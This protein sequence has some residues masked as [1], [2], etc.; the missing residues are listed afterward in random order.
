MN[1]WDVAGADVYYDVRNEF[2]KDTHGVKHTF[3]F[4]TLLQKKAILIYDVTDK[5]SF[6]SLNKWIDE[7]KRLCPNELTL[8]LVANKIDQE[9]RSVYSSEGEKF[10]QEKN[11]KYFETSAATGDG[12]D[13]LFNTL[14]ED[15]LANNF[16][17]KPE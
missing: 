1:F 11:I 5:S 6:D 7:L 8:I 12:V 13:Q 17:K 2:Y 15:I 10:A 4:A 9:P 16:G 14:F 3:L